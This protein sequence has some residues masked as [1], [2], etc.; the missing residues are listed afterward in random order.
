MLWSDLPQEL[1]VFGWLVECCFTST[2]NVGLLGTGAQDGHLDFHTAPE[3][4]QHLYSQ[5]LAII[6][7]IIFCIFFL[8]RVFAWA[9]SCLQVFRLNLIPRPSHVVEE[10]CESGGGPYWAVR[11]TRLLVSVDVKLYWTMLRHWSQLVMSLICQLTSEDIKQ[12]YLP[13]LAHPP[14]PFWRY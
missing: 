4:C 6:I 14:K 9:G 3:L 13:T 8:S 10:L 11:R 1:P 2:E 7:T 5:P 12:H